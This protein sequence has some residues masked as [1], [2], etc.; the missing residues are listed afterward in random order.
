MVLFINKEEL[1]VILIN[2]TAPD[3][4]KIFSR[5]TDITWTTLTTNMREKG[6]MAA[7]SNKDIPVRKWANRPGPSSQAENKKL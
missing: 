7:T 4:S 2:K 5:V 6:S 3:V 1:Y